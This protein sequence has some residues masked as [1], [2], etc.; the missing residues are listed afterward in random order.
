MDKKLYKMK[1]D[2]K[3]SGVCSGFGVYLGVDPTLIRVLWIVGT[4]FTAFLGGII[5]Y[6]A[7]A[8]IIPDEPDY[9]EAEYKEKR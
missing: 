5:L 6:I 2:R 1:D 3:I 7:C 8:I 4:F 9:Y